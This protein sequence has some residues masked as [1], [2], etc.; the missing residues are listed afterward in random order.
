MANKPVQFHEE[1][2]S[3]LMSAFD[4][5]FVRHNVDDAIGKIAESPSR[6]PLGELGTRKLVLA[7]FPFAVIDRETATSIQI[8]RVAHAGPRPGFWRNRF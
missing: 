3:D 6:W 5:Y 7:A 8:V 4:W 1:A 2:S